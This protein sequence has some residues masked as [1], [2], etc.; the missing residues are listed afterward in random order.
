M[1]SHGVET[2]K[3]SEQR[4]VN[5]LSQTLQFGLQ[6]VSP[7]T[8]NDVQTKLTEQNTC[9]FRNIESASTS[10]TKFNCKAVYFSTTIVKEVNHVF[11]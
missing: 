5:L 11:L 9:M 7:K 10:P 8:E 4:A 3:L 2:E 1:N 6:N